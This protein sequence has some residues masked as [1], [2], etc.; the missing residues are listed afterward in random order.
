[1]SIGIHETRIRGL[2][3]S[4][5]RAEFCI[6]KEAIS[7]EQAENLISIAR[8]RLEIEKIKKF[9]KFPQEKW[10]NILWFLNSC[11]DPLRRPLIFGRKSLEKLA[12]FGNVADWVEWL[13]E[14]FDQAEMEGK[15]L[16]EQ[17]LKRPA[18][19]GAEAD[20]LKWEMTLRL[21]SNSH[22]IKQKPLNWWNG[23]SDLIKLFAVDKKKNELL[24]KITLLKSVHVKNL[25]WLAWGISRRFVVALNIGSLGFF[26]WYVPHQISRYYEKIIDL[27]TNTEIGLERSPILKLDWQ[28]HALSDQDLKNTGLCFSMLPGPKDRQKDK[29]FDNYITGLGFLSKN[30]IH[31]QFEANAFE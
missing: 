6:P 11:D 5:D 2:Y 21:Y 10:E 1:M 8:A 31:L 30:D 28:R 22:T 25:W 18:P 7:K 20:K 27:E 17:E 29:L 19:S 24:M 12:E 4:V 15:A 3:V 16:A 26:W 13:K 9:T 14:Q 23:V